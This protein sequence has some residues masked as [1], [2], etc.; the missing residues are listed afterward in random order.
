MVN[1]ERST[2]SRKLTL[3]PMIAEDEGWTEPTR[4]G[5]GRAVPSLSC[6]F[7]RVSFGFWLGAIT[8]GTG[9]CI[10]GGCMP[11]HHPIAVTIS[12]IWWG[13]YIGCLGASLGALF[14]LL[15]HALSGRSSGSLDLPWCAPDDS[16]PGV[17][18][19]HGISLDS[20]GGRQHEQANHSLRLGSIWQ[21]DDLIADY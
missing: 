15:I 9:G 11:Y 17:D 20:N 2:Y 5:T 18:P 19:H 13:M 8:L 4:T 12:V 10:L 14:G 7:D 6:R 3:V 1:T 16:G 21:R